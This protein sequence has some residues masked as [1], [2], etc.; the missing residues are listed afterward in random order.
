MVMA[1][2][3][4]DSIQA[5]PSVLLGTMTP[6]AMEYLGDELD[7]ADRA[8]GLFLVQMWIIRTLQVGV[9]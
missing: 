4:E 1:L 5:L 7:L 3:S 6:L 9:D 2:P 8:R